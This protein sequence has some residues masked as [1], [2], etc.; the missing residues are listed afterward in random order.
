MRGLDLLPIGSIV[1]LYNLEKKVM[2]F[3]ILQQDLSGKNRFDYIGVPYPEG[4]QDP[5]IN[6][7]FNN[8]DVEEVVFRGFE[9][10]EYDLLMVG[11]A[12]AFAKK[13]QENNVN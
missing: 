11:L 6:L 9:D 3:G 8:Q 1:K 10:D 12:E 2:I 5:R 7:G 13:E 4:H